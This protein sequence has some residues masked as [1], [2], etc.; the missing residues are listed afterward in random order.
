MNEKK[1]TT[2]AKQID[3]FLRIHSDDSQLRIKMSQ[4]G[5]LSSCFGID[6]SKCDMKIQI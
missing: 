2:R 4:K 1:V 3:Q 5:L 6:Y